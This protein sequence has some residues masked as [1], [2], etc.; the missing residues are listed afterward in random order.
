MGLIGDCRKAKWEVHELSKSLC[1]AASFGSSLINRLALLEEFD[2]CDRIKSF[3]INLQNYSGTIHCICGEV[4]NALE[5]K[6]QAERKRQQAEKAG[7]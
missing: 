7:D 2:L 3:Q 4:D 6:I 1:D 5:K